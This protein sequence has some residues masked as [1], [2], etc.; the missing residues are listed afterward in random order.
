MRR[1]IV[2]YVHFG[3]LNLKTGIWFLK[4]KMAEAIIHVGAGDDSGLVAA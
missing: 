4:F 2:K 3:N 1:K